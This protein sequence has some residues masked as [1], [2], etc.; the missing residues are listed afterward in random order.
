MKEEAVGRDKRE[1][2][3]GKMG[4]RDGFPQKAKVADSSYVAFGGYNLA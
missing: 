1:G 3:G 4:D 2:E